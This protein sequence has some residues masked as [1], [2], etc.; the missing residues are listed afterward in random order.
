[1]KTSR[2]SP[3]EKIEIKHMA[4]STALLIGAYKQQFFTTDFTCHFKTWALYGSLYLSKL[5]Q[6]ALSSLSRCFPKLA[7]RLRQPL[8][9]QSSVVKKKKKRRK[10]H[11]LG[12][13]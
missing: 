6:G 8:D 5:H 12:R 3:E 2:I 13:I 11:T 10:T 1:M 9:L 7:L 4:P